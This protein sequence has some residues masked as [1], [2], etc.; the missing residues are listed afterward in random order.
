MDTTSTLYLASVNTFHASATSDMYEPVGRPVS[1]RVSVLVRTSSARLGRRLVGL[2]AASASASRVR[3]T[4][5]AS[6]GPKLCAKYGAAAPCSSTRWVIRVPPSGNGVNRVASRSATVSAISVSET[7]PSFAVAE[8]MRN[9]SGPWS[10]GLSV[11]AVPAANSPSSSTD[12]TAPFHSDQVLTSRYRCHTASGAAA[13]SMVCSTDHM[14]P[15]ADRQ[16]LDTVLE[17][18]SQ[19]HRFAGQ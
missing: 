16:M 19:P 10:G 11:P 1:P 3:G 18:R 17:V 6:T 8:M 5:A 7:Y 4:P 15:P 13:V 9:G 12:S 2:V 14:V